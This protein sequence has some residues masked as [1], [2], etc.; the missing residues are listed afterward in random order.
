MVD[1]LLELMPYSNVH[2][3]GMYRT[4]DSVLPVQYYNRL[5]RD[6]VCDVAYIVGRRRRCLY[7]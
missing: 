4:K 5:P 1:A 6:E 2:H 7:I 3:L